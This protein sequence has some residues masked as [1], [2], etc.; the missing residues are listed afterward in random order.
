MISYLDQVAWNEQGLIPVIKVDATPE[1]LLMQGRV[2][3]AH[4]P[5]RWQ[6]SAQYTG[7]APGQNLGAKAKGS[8]MCRDCWRSDSTEK[9][10]GGIAC[11]TDGAYCF[12]Q[13]LGNDA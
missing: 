2:N 1:K 9:Q 7:P 3:R 11:S 13:R 5:L 8:G 6:K 10:I 4:R 12:Y